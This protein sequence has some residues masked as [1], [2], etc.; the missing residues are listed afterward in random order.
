[1]MRRY[2]NILCMYVC[3][4]T[5]QNLEASEFS[6]VLKL[7]KRKSLVRRI[8][9]VPWQQLIIRTPYKVLGVRMISS[10]EYAIMLCY[11]IIESSSVVQSGVI[12][13]RFTKTL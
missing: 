13:T 5:C 4:R 3:E 7:T 12:L 1:M 9:N 6:F 10:P 2:E 8:W 11:Y